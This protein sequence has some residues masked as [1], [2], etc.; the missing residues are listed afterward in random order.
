MD[1]VWAIIHDFP[2]YIVSNYGEVSRSDGVRH[3]AINQTANGLLYVGLSK[4]GRQ[5]IRAV[6]PLVAEAFVDGKTYLFDT[7]LHLDG[8]VQNNRADNLAW[9]PRWFV[10][11]Y[12]RQFN[13]M[14]QWVYS[15][16][17]IN[18]DTEEIYDDILAAA[19]TKGWL[20]DDIR[21]S[22]H[23]GKPIFPHW[24]EVKYLKDMHMGVEY[25]DW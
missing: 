13:M 9:R 21:G 11:K 2:K 25:S 10:L 23:G 6:A 12:M 14:P 24:E 4:D 7:P 5:Y 16:P 22:A 3:M 20:F 15:G 17:L 8:Q 18:T 1:R 19:T